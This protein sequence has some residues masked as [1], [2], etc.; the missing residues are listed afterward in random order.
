MG[1]FNGVINNKTAEVRT[2][3]TKK[4]TNV[5]LSII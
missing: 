1:G 2:I 4:I 3:S 5:P